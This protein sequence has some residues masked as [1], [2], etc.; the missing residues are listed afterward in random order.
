[1]TY[2]RQG[3]AAP[4]RRQGPRIN[5]G[6]IFKNKKKNDKAPDFSGSL[7]LDEALLTELLTALKNGGQAKIRLIGYTNTSA[8][9]DPWIRLLASKDEPFQGQQRGRTAAQKDDSDEGLW[10]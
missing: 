4:P 8:E 1:M 10:R 3:N 9:R 7:E 6:A 5:S 2:S